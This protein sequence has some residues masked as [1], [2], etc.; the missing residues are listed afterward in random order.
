MKFQYR[1]LL[2]FSLCFCIVLTITTGSFSN[3]SQ[4]LRLG[5]HVSGMG[6]LDPHFAAGSQD[7]AVADMIFN[8]LL[9]FVPGD[10]P[11]I[12]P[13]LAREMPQFKIIDGKQVWQILIR[14][15]VMFHAGPKTDAYELTADDVVFSLTKSR[16]RKR[17]A[18]AGEYSG[19]SVKKTGRYE[20]SIT[21]D[22][23][24]SP[25]L[26]FPKISNYSGGFIIS[27]KAI[28][29]MGYDAFKKHPVGT[30][31]FV[32]DRYEK[33]TPLHLVAHEKYFRGRPELDGVQIHFIPDIAERQAAFENGELDIYIGHGKKE[34]LEGIENN[35]DLIIDIHGVGEVTTLHFNINIKPLDDIRVRKAIAYGLSRKAFLDTSI[36]KLAGPVYAPV[37]NQFLPGGLSQKDA[38]LF[39]LDYDQDI[40]KARRLLAQA[41]YPD[42]FTL[43]LV[44]S[45][46][47]VYTAYYAVLKQ[48]LAKINIHCNIKT[49]SHREMHSQIRK[50]PKPLVI[51][52]AWRP[53]ADVYLTR[54][55]HSDS[56][57][58]SGKKPDT[59]FSGFH[60]IDT[61]IESARTQTDPKTQIHLWEQAQIKIL[62]DMIAYPLMYTKQLFIRRPYV[63]YGHTLVSTMA[64]YPQFT[65]KTAI[66]DK[67]AQ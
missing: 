45:E 21:L 10:A 36:P 9:R 47:R 62:N 29:A 57:V 16:D 54:F 55:F 33:G 31:P 50:S 22:T 32:F 19:M 66:R 48:Q 14:S 41:G 27:K 39:K 58:V 26:F 15:G 37:P 30:G 64:L 4:V 59:N 6:R 20:I 8:G 28:E 18:Y 44:S 24:L 53:N 1:F 42:G 17:C 12:E 63:N 49:V 11:R 35:K 43:D 67:D 3:E 46:K 65:E 25:I 61:L 60:Q 56:I 38:V 2:V 40:E 51:Y 23:P 13:D 5:L 52:P 34:W 7:R